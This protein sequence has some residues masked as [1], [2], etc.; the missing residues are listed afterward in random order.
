M[1]DFAF[2]CPTQTTALAL[3]AQVPTWA[4]EFDDP[5]APTQVP[6]P[7]LEQRSYHGAE[8]PNLFTQRQSQFGFGPVAGL[9][10]SQQALADQMIAYWTTFAAT[11]NPNAA[12]LPDLL[13][14]R[15]R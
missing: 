15:R 2:A 6:A 9:S 8:L 7:F 4:Y 12:G 11:G 5:G 14:T 3:S 13:L 1:T 10:A